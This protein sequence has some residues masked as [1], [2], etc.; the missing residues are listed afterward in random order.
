MDSIG[1]LCAFAFLAGFVD[2]IVGGGGL[3]QLPA[4]LILLPAG[5][6]GNIP[7]VFGTNKLAAMCGT[8]VAAAQ[9]ARR[10]SIRWRTI[11]PAA[12]AAFVFSF[13][14]AKVV[15]LVR[16]EFLKPMVL[17]M[18][19]L[20]AVYT[21][22][23]KDLGSIHRP[24]WADS[25]ELWAGVAAGA[26]IGFYDGFFGPGTGS[27]LIFLFIG[28]FGFDFLSA[29]ASAK[30]I[31]VATNLSAMLYFA[32]SGNILYAVALPMGCCN[33]AGAF[34]GSRLAI[35]KGNSFVRVFFLAIVSGLIVR[36]AWDLWR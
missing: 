23:K 16:P 24:R 9:Y 5:V 12:S 6:A 22:W 14:G 7:L 28:V 30:L 10:V 34:L 18:L 36:L 33:I 20:V 25:R 35:L 8:S 11:L 31:N 21:W 26:V 13:L 3:I 32:W 4:M 2:S 19:V 27:F 17:G 29:S 1:Y 15:S